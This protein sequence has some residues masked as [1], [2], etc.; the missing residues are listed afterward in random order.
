MHVNTYL[1]VSFP[2]F[3]L[4]NIVIHRQFLYLRN[5]MHL[6]MP[7]I[8][9]IKDFTTFFITDICKYFTNCTVLPNDTLLTECSEC[10]I[11]KRL[12]RVRCVVPLIP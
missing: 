8:V 11:T 9:I 4:I 10:A 12:V 5:M 2:F 7:N 6:L 1:C 3:F